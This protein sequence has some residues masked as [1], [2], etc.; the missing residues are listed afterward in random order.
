MSGY[1]GQDTS[2][3]EVIHWKGRVIIMLSEHLLQNKT[4]E[5]LMQEARIQIP[6]YSKEWTD[7]NHRFH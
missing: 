5:D 2:C 1:D 6:L 7:F 4:Y 3:A